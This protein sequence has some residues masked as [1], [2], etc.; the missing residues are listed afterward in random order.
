M[1][2]WATA[3]VLLGGCD[4]AFQ[5]T[6]P[7]K[8]DAGIDAACVQ[9]DE[10]GDCVPDAVD[11]CPGMANADQANS[12]EEAAGSDADTV[13]DVCDPNPTL[14]GDQLAQ[15]HGFNVEDNPMLAW[16]D[17]SANGTWVFASGEARHSETTDNFAM[18]R[19]TMP[20]DSDELS[21]EAGFSFGAWGP[22]ATDVRIGLI[23]DANATEYPGHACW[24]TDDVDVPNRLMLQEHITDPVGGFTTSAAFPLITT[25]S[26][27]SIRITRRTS[28]Q[29]LACRIVVEGTPAI[30]VPI[31]TATAPWP[32]ER[33]VAINGQNAAVTLRY[34]VIYTR[35]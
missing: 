7:P 4:V 20:L 6:P 28:L 12:A 27:F 1:A 26:R 15:F 29:Q 21:V 30:D 2:R 32:T 17:T 5:L 13:G 19:R 22:T 25:S 11:N 9:P 31:V 18:L 10:D 3:I 35:P 33:H 8:Q 23:V 24:A 14:G 34:V 16:S